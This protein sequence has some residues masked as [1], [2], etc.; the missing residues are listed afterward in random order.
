[1]CVCEQICACIVCYAGGGNPLAVD[2]FHSFHVVLHNR[3][4]ATY[5]KHILKPAEKRSLSASLLISSA[6]VLIHLI[7][8][9]VVVL[10][11]QVLP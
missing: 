11:G 3:I 5:K 8:S 7:L 1:V 2:G 10:C 4:V 6:T 9:F